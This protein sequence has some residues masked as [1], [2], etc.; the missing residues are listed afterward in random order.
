MDDMDKLTNTVMEGKTADDIFNETDING[1]GT[2]DFEEY[3]QLVQTN[4]AVTKQRKK[5]SWRN[6][7]NHADDSSDFVASL[8]SVLEFLNVEKSESI[9]HDLANIESFVKKFD[10]AKALNQEIRSKLF[11]TLF[12]FYTASTE[13]K[14]DQSNLALVA[15]DYADVTGIEDI[16]AYVEEVVSRKK[17]IDHD[18]S[19]EEAKKIVTEVAEL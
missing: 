10:S 13:D 14:V 7:G 9:I 1:D 15:I 12:H 5:V 16:T 2:L 8:D 11:D 3:L 18:L 17:L 19:L 4:D 6:S